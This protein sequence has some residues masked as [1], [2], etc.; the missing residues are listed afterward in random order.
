MF[1]EIDG[2]VGVTMTI[3]ALAKVRSLLLFAE[4][5]PGLA[6]LLTGEAFVYEEPAS[7]QSMRCVI[8]MAEDSIR[9]TLKLAV[10]EKEIAANPTAAQRAAFFMSFVEGRWRRFAQSGFQEAPSADWQAIEMQLGASA[11]P[12]AKK[13]S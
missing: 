8:T 10:G 11:L 4:A 9:R 6:R 13:S 1:S 7:A 5:N 3:K 2:A 12:G